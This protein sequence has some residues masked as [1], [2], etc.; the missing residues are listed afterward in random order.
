MILSFNEIT[1]H[2]WLEIPGSPLL[3]SVPGLCEG[4]ESGTYS[5]EWH[6]RFKTHRPAGKGEACLR[7]PLGRLDNYR[8]TQGVQSPAKVR[9]GVTENQTRSRDKVSTHRR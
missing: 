7:W 4:E 5:L 8:V 3:W 1:I 6:T 2:H 9:A